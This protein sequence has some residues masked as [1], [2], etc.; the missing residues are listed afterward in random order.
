MGRFRLIPW[1]EV[2]RVRSFVLLMGTFLLVYFV[3]PYLVH[4][5]MAVLPVDSA[6]YGHG[7]TIITTLT[8]YYLLRWVLGE[9]M[10]HI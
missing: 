5:A 2:I 7:V 9:R 10:P 6:R 8:V 3:A 1:C 4:M